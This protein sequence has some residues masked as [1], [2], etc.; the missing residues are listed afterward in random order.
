MARGVR[1]FIRAVLDKASVKKVEQDLDRASKR[2][3]KDWE[4]AS[5]KSS[6]EWEKDHKDA[7]R[8]STAA[9]KRSARR[10]GGIWKRTLSLLRG[11]IGQMA[12]LFGGVFAVQRIVRFG[13][14]ML[15]LGKDQAEIRSRFEIVFGGMSDS[16]DNFVD[17]FR[18]MA[19]VTVDETEDMLSTTGAI[20][21]GLGVQEEQM[22]SLSQQALKLAGDLT[23]F[24]NIPLDRSIEAVNALLIGQ[25]RRLQELGIVVDQQIL[26]QVAFEQTG[27][28]SIASLTAQ[29]L[30]TARLAAA[31]I[32]AADMIGNLERTQLSTAN[33]ARRLSGAL[34]QMKGDIAIALLPIVDEFVNALGGAGGGLLTL[35]DRI[36]Q[37]SDFV[38]ENERQIR[39]WTRAIINSIKVVSQ[40]VVTAVRLV[41]NLMQAS[42][43]LMVGLANQTVANLGKVLNVF[44]DS[45]NLVL[46]GI[47]L[48]PGI[49]LDFRIGGI[50][51]DSFSNRAR[52]AFANVGDAAGDMKD[53]IMDSVNALATLG[54]EAEGIVLT[55]EQ[56]EDVAETAATAADALSEGAGKAGEEAGE[57]WVLG[58]RDSVD[59]MFRTDMGVESPAFDRGLFDREQPGVMEQIFGIDTRVEGDPVLGLDPKFQAM[60]ERVEEFRGRIEDSFMAAA[61]TMERAFGNAFDLLVSEGGNATDFLSAALAGIPAGLLAGIGEYAGSKARENWLLAAEMTA[62]AIAVAVIPGLQGSAG[63]F[64]A[65][66]AQHAAVAAG[67]STLAAAGSAG[68]GALTGGRR[69]GGGNF[70][71]GFRDPGGSIA[72][73]GDQDREP[74]IINITLDPLSPEDER[75]QAAVTQANRWGEERFG[76]NVQIRIHRH[77]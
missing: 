26:K 35:S 42:N 3:G 32:R 29:E 2:S 39:I 52:R 34:R 48:I 74:M 6:R 31:T 75:F 18:R 10:V 71:G 46:A 51:V 27:K 37:F 33:K 30:A 50:P 66:A 68:S 13:A 36:K 53:A 55:S 11:P 21:S 59:Q 14:E 4:E 24:R 49:D 22:A 61:G 43:Q 12:A 56:T 7:A 76:D 38:V 1:W 58:F 67:W 45:L 69:A 60:E 77:S 72:F 20:I 25:R 8:K 65:S 70:G 19:G 57:E 28:T 44:I 41:F 62:R 23:S 64:A 5:E 15:K 54:T 73:G 40:L 9:H 16:V 17:T 47:D 63:A